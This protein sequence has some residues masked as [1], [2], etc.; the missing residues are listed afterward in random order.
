MLSEKNKAWL[1]E[2]GYDLTEGRYSAAVDG[3]DICISEPE[4]ETRGPW[5]Y[6]ISVLIEIRS[7]NRDGLIQAMN[8]NAAEQKLKLDLEFKAHVLFCHCSA[9]DDIAQAVINF[10]KILHSVHAGPVMDCIFCNQGSA[11]NRVIYKEIYV[12]AHLKCYYKAVAQLEKKRQIENKLSLAVKK[13]IAGAFLGALIGSF[14]TLIFMI[15]LGRYS[16]YMAP[17]IGLCA[18]MGYIL[19]GGYASLAMPFIS[20]AVSLLFYAVMPFISFALYISS[21]YGGLYGLDNEKTFAYYYKSFFKAGSTSKDV[22]M[23][24]ILSAVICLICTGAIYFIYRKRNIYADAGKV[25]LSRIAKA[26]GESRE[27]NYEQKSR[28]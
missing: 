23:Q 11:D 9:D 27:L 14:I 28:H 19:I 6:D 21:L 16:L 15:M 7:K 10:T 18:A 4:D 5:A 20:S 26:G 1:A 2:N 24:F 8:R 25:V 17:I 3:Y 13:G 22:L 12:K